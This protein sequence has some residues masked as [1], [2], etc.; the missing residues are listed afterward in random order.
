MART[1]PGL[2]VNSDQ[3]G[4][5]PFASR[6][7]DVG[8]AE[9][10]VV[11]EGP[12]HSK[13]TFL[14]LHGNPTW[15]YLYRNFI[16][17]LA[18]THR[19]IVPDD[20]G[21]GRS[22]KPR[23]PNYYTLER[24]I[25]NLTTLL[26]KLKATNVVVVVQDWGGPIGMGWA[27]RNP[28]KVAGVVVMNTWAFIRDPPFKLPWLFRFLFLGKGGWKRV[29]DKNAFVELILKKRGT[30]RKLDPI[31]VDAYRAPF[32]TPADRIGIGRFPQLIPE[33]AKP[34]HESWATMAATEDKLPKLVGKPALICWAMKDPAFRKPALER[35]K[36]A[37]P[38]AEGPHL[39]PNAGHYLQEDAAPDV[40]AHINAWVAKNWP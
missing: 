13:L 21:F 27:T 8:G 40:L 31:D 19:V 12:R 16:P 3:Q 1:Y 28:S 33:T 26:D 39:L 9:M 35:W 6:R 32:P 38:N 4:R 24:H 25:A 11:D 15:G 14:L 22:A 30:V 20:V 36:R 5:F 7:V 18:K 37:F 10:A 17:E 2:D 23:D 29:V 34:Q